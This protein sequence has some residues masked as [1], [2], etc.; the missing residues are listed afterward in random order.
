MAK[1]DYDVIARFQRINYRLPSPFR[2]KR[3]SAAAVL[4]PIINDDFAVLKVL[5]QH[6]APTRLWS[7]VRLLLGHGRIAGEKNRYRLA[8]T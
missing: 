2:N 1:L 3:A 4:R 7:L 5:S 6:F 8:L